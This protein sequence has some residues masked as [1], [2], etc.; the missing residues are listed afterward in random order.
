M[1]EITCTIEGM[2]CSMCESHIND[3]IRKNFKVK[4]VHSSCKKNQ[5]VIVSATDICDEQ[6]R[7]AIDP[8]GYQLVA[9]TRKEGVKKG[10]FF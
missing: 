9:I 2:Q 5:T 7:H 8:T 1:I 3:I 10:L 6:L 4:K